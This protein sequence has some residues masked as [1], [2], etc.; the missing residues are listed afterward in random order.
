MDIKDKVLNDTTGF[1]P[2]KGAHFGVKAAAFHNFLLNK[3]SEF[4]KNHYYN[5]TLLIMKSK[6]PTILSNSDSGAEHRIT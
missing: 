5:L 1:E 4:K 3:N 6:V 2:V